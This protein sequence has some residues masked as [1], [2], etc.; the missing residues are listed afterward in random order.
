MVDFLGEISADAQALIGAISA[1]NVP[2]AVCTSA[3][4]VRAP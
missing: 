1:Q 2:F 4:L 3:A